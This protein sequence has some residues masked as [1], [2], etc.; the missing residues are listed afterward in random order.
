MP[1]TSG[2]IQKGVPTEVCRRDKLLFRCPETPT[3]FASFIAMHHLLTEFHC[4]H[5]T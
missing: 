4:K 1:L 3:I 2:A 5:N